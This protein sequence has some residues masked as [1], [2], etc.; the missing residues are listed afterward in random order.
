[1]FLIIILSISL[2]IT[3]CLYQHFFPSPN[4]NPN[5]KYVLV[6]GCDSGVGHGLALELDKQGFNVLAGV[7]LADSV[8]SLEKKLSPKATVFRLDITKEEDI[9]ATFELVNGKTKVLHALVNNAGIITHGCIDWTS[10]ELMRKVMDVNFF[11]HVAMTKKFL[12][13]L[14]V[15]R[16]SRV[17]NVCSATGFFAFPNTSAYSSS[18]H[19]FEAFCD[20]LRREM[21]PW[22]LR[23]SIIEPGTLRTAMTDGYESNLRKLWNELS[24]DIQQRWGINFLNNIITQSINS[25]FIIHADDPYKV[26]RAV[27]H[28]VINTNPRIRYRPGWQAKFIFTIFYLPPVWLIDKLLATAL[29]FIPDGVR[30]QI[31]N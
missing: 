11:G 4:I 8:T 7:Y 28:A 23:V 1:M 12:P 18:K 16:N 9:N 6:S 20:C 30:N 17:V 27:Q 25:P 22:G 5:G 24:T 14:I 29:H 19:A 13:L 21:V 26:V 10:L 3:Y 2:Y 15:K 31:L